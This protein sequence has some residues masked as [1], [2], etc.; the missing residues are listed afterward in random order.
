MAALELSNGDPS[1]QVHSHKWLGTIETALGDA[2][3][4]RA[5]LD[6]ALSIARSFGDAE[7]EREILERIA[8]Q[9]ET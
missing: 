5:H 6:Q 4:G 9:A 8:D 3:G 1:F 2:A 7:G